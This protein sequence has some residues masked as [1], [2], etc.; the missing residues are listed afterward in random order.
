MTGAPQSGGMTII[1]TSSIDAGALRRAFSQRDVEALLALYTDDATV[2]VVDHLNQ[3]SAPRRIS[4]RE[5]LRA[6][7]ED[8]FARDM[9][10]A[11]DIVA[12]APDAVGYVLR[13]TYA[14]GTKVVCAATAELRDGRI[15]REVGVQ[16]WDA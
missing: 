3:P 5:Q 14:D 7:L 13:C 9:T 10:H 11:V 8:V 16:A 6:H 1:P 12:S 2:E 4:G 15:A